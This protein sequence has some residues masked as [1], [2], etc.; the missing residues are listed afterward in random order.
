MPVEGQG[1][2]LLRHDRRQDDQRHRLV[3]PHAQ[4]RRREHQGPRRV[5]QGA[6]FQLIL[7]ASQMMLTLSRRTRCPSSEPRA[8]PHH[9]TCSQVPSVPLQSIRAYELE[10]EPK[11]KYESETYVNPDGRRQRDDGERSRYG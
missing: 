2:V 5:L 10:L 4:R 1:C 6:L 3:L 9:P 8:T 11:H 7:S